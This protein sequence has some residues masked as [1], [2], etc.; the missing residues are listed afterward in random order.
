MPK[1]PWLGSDKH[2]GITGL[3]VTKGLDSGTPC[4]ADARGTLDCERRVG[5]FGRDCRRPRAKIC[6]DNGA[7]ATWPPRR[8]PPLGSVFPLVSKG[9]TP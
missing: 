4:I 1:L 5:A 9:A 6:P 7:R 2:T 8:N 3:A